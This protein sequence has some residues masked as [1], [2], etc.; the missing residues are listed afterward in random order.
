[1]SEHLVVRESKTVLK[2][3]KKGGAMLKEQR[4]QLERVPNG[5]M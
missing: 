2:E 5:Q 3:K 4:S 1:M